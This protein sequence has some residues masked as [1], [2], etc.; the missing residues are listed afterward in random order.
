MADENRFGIEV[1]DRFFGLAAA[2]E[3][4]FQFEV[5]LLLALRRGK[6]CLPLRCQTDKR[7]TLKKRGAFAGRLKAGFGELA[8]DELDGP[9]LGQRADAA[10]FEGV[11]AEML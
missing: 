2:G 5:D 8:G 11:T 10:A 1:L 9:L 6:R 4:L 3:L 7:H